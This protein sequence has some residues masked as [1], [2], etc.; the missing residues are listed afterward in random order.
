MDADQMQ[1]IDMAIT[2]GIVTIV[3]HR[4]EPRPAAEAERK[5]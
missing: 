4:Y 2:S 5:L 3:P 1:I